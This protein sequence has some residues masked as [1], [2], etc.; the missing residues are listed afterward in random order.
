MDKNSLVYLKGFTLLEILV[1]TVILA[2]VMTGLAY[3]FLAGRTHLK[4][5]RS[6]IQAAELGRFFLAPL[7][8]F[9]TATEHP[10]GAQNG[11]NQANNCLTGGAGCPGAQTIGATTYTPTYSFT[12]IT[13]T[14]LQKVKVTISWPEPPS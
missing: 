13:G 8:M 5:A 6:R 7:Q 2:L 3:V 14:T 10:S 9:V 4:H 1:S 12:P 11:W